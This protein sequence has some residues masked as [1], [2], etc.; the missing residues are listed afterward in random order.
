MNQ[1]I[2]RP[3]ARRW[4]GLSPELGFFLRRSAPLLAISVAGLVVLFGLEW[5]RAASGPVLI[6]L[7]LLVASVV[8]LPHALLVTLGMDAAR[9]RRR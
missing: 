6:S 8:T 9:W 4:A 5:A 2:G 3:T 1:L 7:A